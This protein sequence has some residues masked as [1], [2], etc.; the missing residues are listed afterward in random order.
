MLNQKLTESRMD[1]WVV[2]AYRN[3]KEGMEWT[4]TNRK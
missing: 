4:L 3:G 1:M 2:T